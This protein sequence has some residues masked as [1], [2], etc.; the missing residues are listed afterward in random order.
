MCSRASSAT[1]TFGRISRTRRRLRRFGLC[2]P[3]AVL[4]ER[5]RGRRVHTSM[6]CGGLLPQQIKSD[7]SVER[8]EIAILVE[9]LRAVAGML[10]GRRTGLYVAVQAFG[11]L[12]GFLIGAYLAR[13]MHEGWRV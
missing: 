13:I 3:P 7:F 4:R 9:M 10:A 2:R 1:M 8:F 11:A 12:I 5:A 6:R